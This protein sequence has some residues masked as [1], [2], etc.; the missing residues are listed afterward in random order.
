MSSARATPAT[1]S[2]QAP[3]GTAAT[4]LG[5]RPSKDIPSLATGMNQ[6]DDGSNV[7]HGIRLDPSVQY[8]SPACFVQATTKALTGDTTLTASETLGGLLLIDCG[9]SGRAVTYP[10]AALLVA[11]LKGATRG[12]GFH[13]YVRNTSDGAETITMTASTGVT[14]SGTATVAQNDSGHYLIVFTNV[15]PGSE[16][17]TAYTLA[18]DH[19]H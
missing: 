10:T 3:L 2:A 13:L 18:S 16:A 12:M 8:A 15:E 11:R 9:G 6:W 14:L 19:T 5:F 7:T 17:A 1:A 4:Q